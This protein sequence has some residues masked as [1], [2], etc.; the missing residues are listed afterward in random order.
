MSVGGETDQEFSDFLK[1]K[2]GTLLSLFVCCFLAAQ[3]STDAIMQHGETFAVQ[4][5][6]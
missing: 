4:V 2:K 1:T 6:C 3:H 5:E